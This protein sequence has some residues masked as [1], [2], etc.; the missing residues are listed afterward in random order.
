MGQKK[1]NIGTDAVGSGDKGSRNTDEDEIGEESDPYFLGAVGQSGGQRIDG[2][3]G[4]KEKDRRYGR[5]HD[6]NHLDENIF[7]C[8]LYG[9]N[10]KS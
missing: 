10:D 5:R 8:L 1:E 4:Q 2:Y 9:K 7:Y 3:G 6:M